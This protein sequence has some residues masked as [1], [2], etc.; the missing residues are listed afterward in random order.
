MNEQLISLPDPNPEFV[1]QLDRQ[2]R[3]YHQSMN[4]RKRRS[5]RWGLVAAFLLVGLLTVLMVPATRSLAQGAWDELF[6]RAES[7]IYPTGEFV[8]MDLEWRSFETIAEAESAQGINIYAPPD[9]P[10][11]YVLTDIGVT[12]D[13]QVVTLYY[14]RPGRGLYIS[15]R[16]VSFGDKD[17]LIG[18]DA[19]ITPVTVRGVEGV[20]VIGAWVAERP[21]EGFT[22]NSDASFRSLRWVED[23]TLY[24][25]RTMGGSE[26]HAFYIGLEE[27]LAMAESME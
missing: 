23:D 26:G 21:S 25:I 6:K 2:L 1:E 9:A 15:Q 12:A 8:M 4:S 16:K 24:E 11:G 17:G 7:T 10:F 5:Y 13:N 14:D 20:Y 19:N 27:M 22:W 18:S 3:Q